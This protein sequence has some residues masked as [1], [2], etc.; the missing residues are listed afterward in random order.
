MLDDSVA[1]YRYLALLNTAMWKDNEAGWNEVFEH[2]EAGNLWLCGA[3]IF[4]S[5]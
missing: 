3:T 1:Y 5:R 2:D 4:P